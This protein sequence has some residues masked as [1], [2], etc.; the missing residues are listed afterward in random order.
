[1]GLIR[2]LWDA[3]LAHRDIKPANLLIRDGQVLLIDVFFTEVH[4]SPWRQA[5]DLANMMLCLALRSN[6]EQVYRRA[7]L[8]FSVAEIS[9]AFAAARGLALPS[10][11]RHLMRD[12]G[13]DLHAEFASLLPA[14]PQPIRIQR[15]SARRVALLLAM[16]LVALLLV[17]TIRFVL[18]NDDS[19]LTPLNATSIDCDQL[20]PLWL[21]AQSVPSASLVPC[22]RSAPPGWTFAGV[23]VRNGWSQF[24][25]NDVVGSGRLVV[26]LSA[27]CDTTGTVQTRSDQPGTRRYEQTP[28]RDPGAVATWYTV[29]PGGCVT[30]RLLDC[31]CAGADLTSQASSAIGFT[32]RHALQQALDE[33]SNGRLHLDPAEGE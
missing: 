11:L 19:N 27:T 25:L 30:A 28:P 22:L 9:E 7:V 2:R 24:T 1:M 17:P 8:Q 15:W 10:Q 6:P 13:R 18:V 23:N 12:Q 29:F 3:N 4:P 21:E 14:P 16:I 5:V 33:R 26:R 31:P 32:T 20:E